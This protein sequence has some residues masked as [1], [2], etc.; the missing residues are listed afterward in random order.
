MRTTFQS[1]AKMNNLEYLN[2]EKAKFMKIIIK[3]EER[4]ASLERVEHF[5]R[6]VMSSEISFRY[7]LQSILCR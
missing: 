3:R 4:M 6:R 2:T 7:T 1:S 5:E